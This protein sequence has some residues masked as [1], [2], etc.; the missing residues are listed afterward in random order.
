MR[1][2][3]AGPAPRTPQHRRRLR[4]IFLSDV[5][6]G[7]RASKGARLVD[8]LRRHEADAIYLVGDIIDG[9][10]LRVRW[11]WPRSHSEVIDE[12]LRA[13]RAGA[14]VVYVPGNHDAFLR[15]YCGVHFGGIEVAEQ[16]LHVAADG[17]RYLVVHG[18]HFDAL[19]TAARRAALLGALANGAFLALSA[20]LDAALVQCGLPYWSLAQRAKRKVK[21]AVKYIAAYEHALI[22]WARGN[23]ADGVIC[24]HIH[25]AVIREE[26]GVRYI[27]CGDWI[28]SCT[29]VAER[30]DGGFEIVNWA[31]AAPAPEPVPALA[32]APA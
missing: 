20:A 4:A 23:A 8:F 18:D 17:R 27:N 2:G 5:H 25:H 12:M 29:A 19:A 14:R 24:G 15:D 13:A 28:E 21:T 7:L 22:D 30:F 11:H 26:A 9:W 16:A 3:E 1:F 32:E 6:L 10:R 31:D